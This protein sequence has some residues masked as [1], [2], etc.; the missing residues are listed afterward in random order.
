MSPPAS[1]SPS[2]STATPGPSPAGSSSGWR[3]LAR[4]CGSRASCDAPHHSLPH[5]PLSTH[6]AKLRADMRI[7]LKSLQR[8][9]NGTFVL[10]THDQA[11]AMS[12]ADT[13]VVMNAGRLQQVGAP[14]AV[15]RRPVN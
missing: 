5:E 4:F 13:L 10:V 12:L 11:E 2:C 14:L 15:Y 7:E 9:L 6:D 8:Q 3:S 1:R